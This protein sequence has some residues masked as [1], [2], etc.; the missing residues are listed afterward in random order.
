V[1]DE[2]AAFIAGDEKARAMA[3]GVATVVSR[4]SEAI[5]KG[6]DLIS[7]LDEMSGDYK[8]TINHNLDATAAAAGAVAGAINS[9][10]TSHTVTVNV[11]YNDPGRPNQPIP[12][13]HGGP[14]QAGRRYLVGEVGPELFVPS[15]NGYV[16]PN[17]QIQ[18]NHHYNLT[19]NT[20]AR[21]EAALSDFHT[22]RALAGV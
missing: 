17:N 13:Q 9:I 14:V 10:P 21:A 18:N 16:I 15:T 1:T 22:M 12:T 11:H 8:V 5:I 7:T 4:T 3:D 20:S 2:V 19:I 6:D